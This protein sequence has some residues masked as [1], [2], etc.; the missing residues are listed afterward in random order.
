MDVAGDVF[1]WW[2]AFASG[3]FA[4]CAMFAGLAWGDE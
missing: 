4:A 2:V 3:F 1:L